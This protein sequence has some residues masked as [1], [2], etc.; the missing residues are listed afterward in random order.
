MKFF[1]FLRKNYDTGLRM[2]GAYHFSP[3]RFFRYC[4]FWKEAARGGRGWL[5]PERQT[6]GPGRRRGRALLFVE[7]G[8][9]PAYRPSL[10]LRK[11]CRRG[12][13]AEGLGSGRKREAGPRAGPDGASGTREAETGR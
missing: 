3:A 9:S 4:F 12:L 2:A 10:W 6:R 13:D 5:E 1:S 7:E 11:G 8:P